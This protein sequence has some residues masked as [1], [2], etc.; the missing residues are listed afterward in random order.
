VERSIIEVPLAFDGGGGDCGGDGGG[1][2]GV[3][4]GRASLDLDGID[5][6]FAAGGRTL[7]LCQPYNPLGRCFTRDELVALSEV[8]ARRGGRVVSDEIHG[9]LTY[10]VPH[11][12]YASVSPAAAA[13]TLTVTAASKAWNLPGL[14][15]A[16]VITN[17]DA[18]EKVWQGIPPIKNDGPS[19]FGIVASI[20][21]YRDGEP[22]LTAVL[23]HLDRNRALLADLLATHLPGVGYA[24][25]AATYLAWLDFRSLDLPGEPAD[26][27][28][29]RAR[30]AINRGPAFGANGAGFARLNFA[31]TRDILT[32]AVV[33]MA[34]AVASR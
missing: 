16:Q 34:A 3:G 6:A 9:S 11:V 4:A 17:S 2:G 10:G 7:I 33:A 29:E 15:C 14:K 31:T 30:V 32:Q 21:A 8:V 26:F 23:A 18:D 1:D 27:F 5:R 24:P 13:H 12:P 19:T 22:W 28:L 20:A 25:P